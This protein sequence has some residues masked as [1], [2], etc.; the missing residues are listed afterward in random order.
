MPVN[1]Q[2]PYDAEL[3]L[4][5]SGSVTSSGAESTIVDIG[6]GIIEDGVIVIDVTTLEVAS[7]DEIYTICLEGSNVAAMT[8][9]S[10]TLA[11]IEMGNAAA[12]ADADTATGRFIVPFQNEQN[13]T[14]YR[15]VRAH[16]IVAGTID[17]TGITYSAFISTR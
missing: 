3:N 7:T 1:Q 4:K 15:Y 2:Y 13:N 8:S 5:D 16:T 9:G 11:R 17:S 10:V 14:L 12:P 6:A